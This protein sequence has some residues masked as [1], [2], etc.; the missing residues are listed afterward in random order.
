MRF[1]LFDIDGTLLDS[2]G[3]GSRALN[4]AFKE[5]FSVD[6]AFRT[7]SMAGKT[8]LQIMLEGAKLYGIDCSNGIMPAFFSAY[9]R[10]LREQMDI[11][12]G[13]VKPGIREALEI[14]T[15][16]NKYFLG[17][18]T[19]NIEKGARIKLESF[20]LSS[21]FRIGAFGSDHEDR[22]RLLPV[23]V[24][25]L[26]EQ[27]SCPVSFNDCVVIGDTPRDI[28]CSKPYGA[29]AIAVATGPYSAASLAAAGADIIFEDL[30]DTERFIS[31]LERKK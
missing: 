18:L 3:A 14:L 12:K 1:I 29:Y 17:L 25:K 23:A 4:L 16:C 10:H 26:R 22:N 13:H 28:D 2:G 6:D 9:V 19:G 7:V 8:D 21:Y 30:S 27:V 11:R 5:M 31:A 15:S 24:D 20:G